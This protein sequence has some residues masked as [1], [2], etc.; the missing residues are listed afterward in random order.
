MS[1]P[2][3]SPL[4]D[5]RAEHSVR[6][7]LAVFETQV[8]HRRPG[9]AAVEPVSDGIGFVRVPVC[10]DVRISHHLLF[11][12]H[13]SKSSGGTYIARRFSLGSL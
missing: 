4:E 9:V 2:V 13:R 6:R 3:L 8:R 5:S 7:E 12:I 10:C 1:S 11:T